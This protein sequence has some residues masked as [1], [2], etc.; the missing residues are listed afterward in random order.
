MKA[1]ANTSQERREDLKNII[2][3]ENKIVSSVRFEVSRETIT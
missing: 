2:P 1:D 3:V